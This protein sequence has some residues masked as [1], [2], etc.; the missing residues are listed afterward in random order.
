MNNIVFIENDEVITDSLMV[1][2]VFGKE[3]SKVIRAIESLQCS[4][5]FTEAN[6]GLSDYKDSSGKTNKKYLIKRDGVSFLVMG[7]IG[8]EAARFKE[9]YITEFNRME[10]ELK[11]RDL[12]SYMIDDPIA[13]AKRWIK[14]QQEKQLLLVQNKELS[15][16]IIEAKPKLDMY[17]A[18]LD[19]EGHCSIGEF[20]RRV[21][22]GRNTLFEKLR[23]MKVL[24][25]K[26]V[27]YNMPYQ[28]HMKYFKI[29]DSVK[30][31]KQYRVTVLN[32]EGCVWLHKKLQREKEKLEPLKEQ[33]GDNLVV[34][35]NDKAEIKQIEVGNVATEWVKHPEEDNYVADQKIGLK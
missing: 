5:K 35:Y 33:Y 2:E 29:I 22:I 7:F 26:G 24:M 12:N 14:E 6:F 31:G 18:W 32:K 16:K 25:N 4:E 10:Q 3:H 20:G 23:Q 15:E 17:D 28:R 34:A 11:N 27:N 1:A 8:F 30:G 21:N 13:R 19:V 9:M